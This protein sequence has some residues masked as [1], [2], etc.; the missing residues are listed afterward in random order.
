MAT[1]QFNYHLAHIQLP[2]SVQP[3]F[4][5]TYK[6]LGHVKEPVPQNQSCRTTMTLATAGYLR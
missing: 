2:E 4:Y 6:L 5:L 3:N 1:D